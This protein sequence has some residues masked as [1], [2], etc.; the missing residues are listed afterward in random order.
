MSVK[1]LSAVFEDSRAEGAAFTV[2]LAMADWADH[3]GRCYP[4]YRQIA[5]KARVSRASVATAITK[6]IELDELER[7]TRGHTPTRGEDDEAP[8]SVERQWRNT[9]RI[10]LVKSKRQG[11]PASGPPSSGE[12]VQPGDHSESSDG[13]TGSPVGTP[14]GSPIDGGE[15]V[16]NTD[17][18]IR[19][20]PSEDPSGDPSEEQSASAA[21]PPA[22]ADA[23]EAFRT[24]WNETTTAPLKPCLFLTLKRRRHIRA[25]LVERP[26]EA[27]REVF[28]RVEQSS[29]C[30]G[31]NAR[32]FVASF[33]WLISGPD[34]AVKVLEGQYDDHFSDAELRAAGHERFRATCGRCIHTPPCAYTEDC[35]LKW[36]KALRA[37]KRGAA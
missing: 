30:R 29:F 31:D 5:K 17:A 15:V 22:A 12:V 32:G 1:A 9:Y 25:C 7:V 3:N 6:L 36:A 23:L 11:S 19:N 10:L 34:P 8:L 24:L 27:W 37:R 20:S 21:P 13:H 26:L 35:V 2:L 4:S 28:A 33:D 16:Q 18:H 14:P